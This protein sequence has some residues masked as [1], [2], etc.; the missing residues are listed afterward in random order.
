MI[1]LLSRAF[2]RLL[3]L[4]HPPS[5]R[6]RFSVEMLGIFDEPAERR[7]SIRLILD[8]IRSFFFQWLIR[9]ALWIYAAAC[10]G[11]FLTLN[12]GLHIGLNILVP[13]PIRV[14]DRN[15]ETAVLFVVA[16]G[17]V[18]AIA[19]TTTLCVVWFRIARRRH[20]A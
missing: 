3:L 20:H 19:L 12:I 1:R 4:L 7:N 9:E 13:V 14:A 2:Y 10:A 5:F 11:A 18:L 17:S 15:S 6:G 8:A 16:I